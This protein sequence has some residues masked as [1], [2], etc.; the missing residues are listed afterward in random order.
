[1]AKKRPNE[2]R[3]TRSARA[4]LFLA[5]GITLVLLAGWIYFGAV[6]GHYEDARGNS[7][8][9]SPWWALPP[10]AAG[11]FVFQLGWLFG[12]RAYVLVNAIA[13]E[14]F[15]L[16]GAPKGML[17]FPWPE[18]ETVEFGGEGDSMTVHIDDEEK[19]I[20][21]KPVARHQR[22]LLRRAIEGRLEEMK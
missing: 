12:R 6:S 8:Q 21:L 2:V 16:F 9:W 7:L 17:V 1:M 15:P 20:S 18:V 14:V 10:F 19:C 5:A 4:P 13:I 11:L 3:F 22:H